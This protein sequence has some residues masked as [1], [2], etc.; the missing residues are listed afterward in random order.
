MDKMEYI[1]VKWSLQG[2]STFRGRDGIKSK[3]LEP[4]FHPHPLH[5][6]L[7]PALHVIQ[8][9]DLLLINFTL[10]GRQLLPKKV[11]DGYYKSKWQCL[12]SVTFP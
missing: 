11:R 12:L 7:L 1:N 10:F 3:I 5:F 2:H 4:Q 6:T 9:K 8:V